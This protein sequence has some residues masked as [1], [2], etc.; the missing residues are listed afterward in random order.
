M[1]YEKIKEIIAE[2]PDSI[3]FGE[4]GFG[5][6]DSWIEKAQNRLGVKFPPSYIWWLKNY[7]GGEINGEE[8]FSI[9]EIDFEQVVGGDLVYINELNRKNGVTT[10]QELTIQ[11][12]DQGESY[13]LNLNETNEAGENPVYSAVSRSKYADNFLD[14]LSKKLNEQ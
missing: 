14:F 8:V 5:A 11:E 13:Y 12:N 3:S 4:Y 2:N 1:D 10:H 7:N 6:S 9:Y